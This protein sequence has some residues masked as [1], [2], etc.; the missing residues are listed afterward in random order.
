MQCFGHVIVLT[1]HFGAFSFLKN[2]LIG[3]ADDL[4]LMTFVPSPGVRVTVAK[5]MIRDLGMVCQRWKL[6]G[7]KLN[8]SKTKTMIVFKMNPQSPPLTIGELY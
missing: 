2:N 5:S 4:N 8:G 1:V 7:I 6:W 3:Y